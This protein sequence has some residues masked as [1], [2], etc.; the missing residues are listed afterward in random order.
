MKKRKKLSKS[1]TLKHS[2]ASAREGIE[3]IFRQWQ[4][5]R[6]DIDAEPVLIYGPISRI[7]ADVTARIDEELAPYKLVR[8][9]FDVLTALRRTGAP[10]CLSPKELTQYLVLSGAGLNGRLNTLERLGYIV[11]LP[12]PN[13]R[14][15]LRI[16]LTNSGQRIVNKLTPLLF[17]LQW[18]MLSG[19]S[20]TDRRSFS[21][22]LMRMAETIRSASDE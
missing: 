7:Q 10:F 16:Q 2:G 14:R 4:A 20:A 15:T 9:T 22:Y 19:F 1:S 8:G 12:E 13:D 21:K 11:R 6:P 5:E 18:T 3:V 17:N